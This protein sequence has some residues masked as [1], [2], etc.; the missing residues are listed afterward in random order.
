MRLTRTQLRSLLLRE[1]TRMNEQ[2]AARNRI[3]ALITDQT[4][5]SV[6]DNND[7]GILRER[8]IAGLRNAL[9]AVENA[10]TPAEM[11]EILDAIAIIE[12]AS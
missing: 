5:H 7:P 11:D 2:S 3:L 8:F 4:S 9:N 10:S 12:R 6:T 1:A